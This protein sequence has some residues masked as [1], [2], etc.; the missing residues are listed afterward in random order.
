LLNLLEIDIMI[1]KK[2]HPKQ[3]A[4]YAARSVFGGADDVMGHAMY[5]HQ[6]GRRH[7]QRVNGK[8]QRM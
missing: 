2:N 4:H 6:H 5:H 8:N 3:Q 7:E 1:S